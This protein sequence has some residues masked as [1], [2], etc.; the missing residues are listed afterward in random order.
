MADRHKPSNKHKKHTR[1]D[2][3]SMD[4]GQ[5]Q[6]LTVKDLHK[7][8]KDLKMSEISGMIKQDLI[9]GILEKQAEKT[10]NIYATGVL[11]VLPDGYGFL[12]FQIIVIYLVQMTFMYHILKS[13]ALDL[14]QGI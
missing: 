7:L 3:K 9:K 11:E 14:K 6:S 5:L 10:G 13:N 4:T 1:Y 8:A 12:R 2:N